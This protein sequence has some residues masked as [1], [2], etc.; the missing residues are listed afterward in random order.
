M[1]L[2]WA[3]GLG[4]HF[5]L[6]ILEKSFTVFCESLLMVAILPDVALPGSENTTSRQRK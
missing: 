4:S 5:L 1:N 6:S 2:K 3:L